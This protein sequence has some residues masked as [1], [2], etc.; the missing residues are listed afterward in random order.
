MSAGCRCCRTYKESD[1]FCWTEIPEFPLW[2]GEDG[3]KI[4]VRE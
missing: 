3:N 4:H 1:I 2:D